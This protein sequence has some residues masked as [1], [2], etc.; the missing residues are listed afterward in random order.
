MVG[1]HQRGHDRRPRCQNVKK[2]KKEK[3]LPTEAVTPLHRPRKRVAAGIS[4]LRHLSKSPPK[5]Q[6]P[7][8]PGGRGGGRGGVA[9]RAVGGFTICE[10]GQGG[11]QASTTATL[12]T[13]KI[14]R[15][16]RLGTAVESHCSGPH[17][18]RF[19]EAGGQLGLRVD[20]GNESRRSEH[21]ET[22]RGCLRKGALMTPWASK[23]ATA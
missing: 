6:K 20:S 23:T 7:A 2:K 15:A 14:R 18:L 12:S 11:E 5:S 9:G 4:H 10:Q 17:E 21:G 13:P 8:R 16:R 22:P 1:G 3:K 19:I